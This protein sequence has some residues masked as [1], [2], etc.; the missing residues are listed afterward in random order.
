TFTSAQKEYNRLDNVLSQTS[1]MKSIMVGGLLFNSSRQVAASNLQEQKPKNTMKKAL[2]D[3][4]SAAARL[5]QLDRPAYTKV[6]DKID[7]F[8]AHGQ[9]MHRVAL[10]N[11]KP[12]AQASKEALRLWR[13]V[14]FELQDMIK[15]A[16]SAA[17]KDKKNFSSL[18]SSSQ[19]LIA[20]FSV[21]GLLFFSV[22]IFFV[23][24]SILRPIFDVNTQ[25]TQLAEGDG[26][27][28]RELT[29]YNQDELGKSCGS[30]N[31][32][33][34][35]ILT[36]VKEAKTL[37]NE[38]ASIAHE[39]STTS[40][41]VGRSS[42]NS[43][44]IIDDA[45]AKASAIKK[46]IHSAIEE[47]RQNKEN[48]LQANKDLRFAKE[49]IDT[50]TN[51]VSQNAQLETEV[52]GNMQELSS[53]AQEVKSVLDVIGDIA[54]QTNLLALNAAIEAARAGEHGRGFAVVAD[55]VRKLAER[56]QKSLV[57]IDSTISVIVQSINDATEKMN[58]NAKEVEALSR[59]SSDVDEHLSNAVEKVL[60]VVSSSEKSVQD[61]IQTG[62]NVDTIVEEVEKINKL[63][64]NNARSVEEIASAASHLGSVTDDLNTKLAQFKT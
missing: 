41:S 26:D 47:A 18:L 20:I 46:E 9:K 27:L 31:S 56:T 5:K 64:A 49:E 17:A 29:I 54:D 43:I 44:K 28:T 37:S 51:R 50:L 38:N 40:D 62:N 22:L 36:L 19:Q 60:G 4:Q 15:T 58:T 45:T 24:R 11:Q 1:A 39:L 32:F 7:A 63:S 57:E 16:S 3:V 13:E 6:A 8:V 30:I 53:Q 61:F 59:V 42:Q 48:I 21:I 23:M 34:R 55:E 35:K 14:K 52:A 25:A 10:Q 33:I 2:G 12:S